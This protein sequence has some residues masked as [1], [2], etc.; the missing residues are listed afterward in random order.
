MV[1]FFKEG[2]WGMW[3]ILFIGIV[4]LGAAG[5]FAA[6]PQ[7][8]RIG[9]LAGM[10]ASLMFAMLYAVST[11]LGTVFGAVAKLYAKIPREEV[12]PILLQGLKESSRPFTFG[13]MILTVAALLF[14]AGM[15][16]MGPLTGAPPP[17]RGGSPP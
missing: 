14:A 8:R 17:D 13:T 2:G 7:R 5:W 1:D 12:V 11:D 10:T 3:A 6:R 15:A 9:F 4:L 16:R